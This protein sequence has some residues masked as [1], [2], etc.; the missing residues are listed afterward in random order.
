[1]PEAPNFGPAKRF[2]IENVRRPA[3]R[4]YP[5]RTNTRR[6]ESD[7]HGISWKYSILTLMCGAILVVGF[8]FAGKL[9]FSSMDYGIRNSKLRT[10]LDEL[11]SEKRRLLLRREI[12]LSPAELLRS[13]RKIGF[14]QID[15]TPDAGRTG[16]TAAPRK[17]KGV[18]SDPPIVQK[19]VINR[20]VEVVKSAQ[21]TKSA[22]VEKQPGKGSSRDKKS[23]S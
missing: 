4:D 22:R 10:Q 1:V 23:R 3:M 14:A 5:R 13:A 6:T 21:S 2:E 20:P 11:E 15:D 12:S 16:P 8:F 19:I 17:V 7:R 9:H 18:I